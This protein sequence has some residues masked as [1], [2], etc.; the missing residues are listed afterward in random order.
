MKLAAWFAWLAAASIACLGT[1]VAADEIV[2][3]FA[4]LDV[5]QAHLNA[6]VHH[7]WAE[8][9]NKEAN[10]LFKVQV[11][12]G[13][14]LANHGNIYNQVVS[15][16]VQI[17]WGL[18]S[19]AGKFPL[20]QVS[21]LPYFS[22]ANSETS[23]IALWRLYKSGLLDQEFDQIVPLKLIVFPQSGVQF[24]KQPPA[25][26][27]LNGLKMIA[28][29]KIATQVMQRLGA[30]PLSFRVD[31]YYE[32]L[33]R[34]TADGVMTGWTAFNPF[35]LAE[36]THYHLD[37]PLGGETGYVF[38]AKKQ[39]DALPEPVRAI[40][41][42]NSGEGES[43]AFGRFWDQVVKEGKEDTMKK[44]GHTLLK[45]TE[46]QAKGW[47]ERVTPIA[48]EWSKSM[49]DAEKVLSTYG[50]ILAKLKSGS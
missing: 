34:G 17:G 24:R 36:V 2:L 25:L 9:I 11:F 33:Q 26:D 48:A 45:L 27:N 49:P 31:E 38:M 35:K 15:N 41:A 46:A 37:V 8:K 4:T 28:G 21:A 23:S 50:E 6:R 19:L 14:A 47:R 44:P 32:T 18:P 10:G 42:K 12:D 7:P 29:S 40:L 39:W 1:P 16:V 5:P 43:R 13:A 22:N 20:L 3:K 30:A